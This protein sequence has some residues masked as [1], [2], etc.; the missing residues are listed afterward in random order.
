MY[1]INNFWFSD[2]V[3]TP[4]ELKYFANELIKRDIKLYWIARTRFDKKFTLELCKLLKEAGCV[5]IAFGLETANN[6][7]AALMNKRPNIT[8]DDIDVI[9]SNFRK[10]KLQTHF[11]LICGFPTESFEELQETLQ[12]VEQQIRNDNF[13]TFA[14]NYFQL[15]H[16]SEMQKN[17]QNYSIAHVFWPEGDDSVAY[18]YDFI[19]SNDDTRHWNKSHMYSELYKKFYMNIF[20]AAIHGFDINFLY[21]TFESDMF[22]FH[23]KKNF[24]INPFLQIDRVRKEFVSKLSENSR[25]KLSPYSCLFN[26]GNSFMVFDWVTGNSLEVSK[27]MIDVLQHLSQEGEVFKIIDSYLEKSSYIETKDVVRDKCFSMFQKLAEIGTLIPA[28]ES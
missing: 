9:L 6:R 17:Y 14:I 19:L 13:L 4:G 24:E 7:I 5:T 3:I 15:F 20:G 27:E 22:M 10:A 16:G 21:Y 28:E 11:C 23:F 18:S 2:E 12:F 25:V 26:I 1:N 8:I